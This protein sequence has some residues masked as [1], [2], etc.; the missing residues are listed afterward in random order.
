MRTANPVF[1]NTSF[2]QDSGFGAMLGAVA[3]R[4]ATMSVQGT[5]LKTLYL[6]IITAASAAASWGMYR[7]NQSLIFPT[8]IGS[9]VGGLAAGILI[10]KKPKIAGFVVPVFA[11]AEGLFVAAFSAAIL[12][13]SSLA[14]KV[15]DAAAYA[16]MGQ[17]AGLTIA[18]AAAMLFGY[19]SG[20]LRLNQF[21]IKMII[22]M[23]A[24]VAIY[25]VGAFLINMVFRGPQGDG[26]IPQLGWQGGAIG[27]GFSVF[28]VALASLNLLLDFQFIDDGVKR[29]L[30]KHYEWIGAFGLLTTL[31]WLYIE[32]LR[33]LAK[34][35][36]E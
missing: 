22:V 24:G 28:V 16:M 11:F 13:Y 14:T 32:M 1:N 15:G 21:M 6:L 18:I 4:P 27:I 10:M 26:I 8:M 36:S 34:L 33:L 25:Y 2:G 3:D 30:P 35:R 5:A 17:A 20:V 9:L 12:Y 29:G 23:T 7:S 19:A 31:V